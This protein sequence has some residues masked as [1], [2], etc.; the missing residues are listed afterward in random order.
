MLE[1]KRVARSEL[2]ELELDWE[3]C[4]VEPDGSVEFAREGPLPGPWGGS[5]TSGPSDDEGDVAFGVEK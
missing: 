2:V 3:D 1:L 5:M 4:E